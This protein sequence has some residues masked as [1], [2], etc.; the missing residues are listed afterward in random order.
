MDALPTEMVAHIGFFAGAEGLPALRSTGR[1]ASNATVLHFAKTC[2]QAMRISFTLKSLEK[3]CLALLHPR[4]GPCIEDITFIISG[5]E[6]LTPALFAK[7]WFILSTLAARRQRVNIKVCV[8]A[9]GVADTAFIEANIYRILLQLVRG[10]ALKACVGVPII[11]DL[12]SPPRDPRDAPARSMLFTS[13]AVLAVKENLHIT[14][15][16]H[17]ESAAVLYDTARETLT[18]TNLAV[19]HLSELKHLFSGLHIRKL[20]V[21]NSELDT[22]T[23]NRLCSVHQTTLNTVCISNVSLWDCWSMGDIVPTSWKHVLDRLTGLPALFSCN[24]SELRMESLVPIWDD[25]RVQKDPVQISD[26][27]A[28]GIVTVNH[29]LDLLITATQCIDISTRAIHSRA[30]QET[31]D[32]ATL[33]ASIQQLNSIRVLKLATISIYSDTPGIQPQVA[34][35]ASAQSRPTVRSFWAQKIIF[36]VFLLIVRSIS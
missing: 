8:S 17:H 33:A 14:F 36:Q 24:L 27:F 19:K 5:T 22:T 1:L 32:P 34:Y 10:S 21:R 2:Y 15:A 13:L 18:L 30:F 35:P 23:L 6:Q 28:S 16:D 4:F 12:P 20:V 31:L 3:L 11:L 29:R 7:S 26:F 9:I 25:T